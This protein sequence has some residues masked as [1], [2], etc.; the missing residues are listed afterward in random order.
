[1]ISEGG[2]SFGE[3]G[4]ILLVHTYIEQMAT[5]TIKTCDVLIKKLSTYGHHPRCH[6][7]KSNHQLLVIIACKLPLMITMNFNTIL[8]VL[9]AEV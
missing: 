8:Y 5:K 9:L 2:G 7:S 3:F 1:M 6:T 4:S